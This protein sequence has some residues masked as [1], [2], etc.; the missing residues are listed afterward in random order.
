MLRILLISIC[1]CLI[2]TFSS[3][4]NAAMMHR[5]WHSYKTCDAKS[6]FWYAYVGHALGMFCYQFRDNSKVF[7]ILALFNLPEE[8][9]KLLQ[10]KKYTTIDIK[11]RIDDNEIIQSSLLIN[12]IDIANK[13]I[14]GFLPS[15]LIERQFLRQIIGGRKIKFRIYG[16]GD[17]FTRTFS[18]LGATAAIDYVL[19]KR[20]EERN[21]WGE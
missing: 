7:P 19:N 5:D 9:I 17:P 16:L 2:S 1:S 6:C 14:G 15:S 4:I 10:S 12:S 13:Q 18:L 8:R 21:E 11:I 3:N 20:S